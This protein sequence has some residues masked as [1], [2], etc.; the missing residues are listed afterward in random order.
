MKKKVVFQKRLL[1]EAYRKARSKGVTK[2]EWQYLN[3]VFEIYHH[4]CYFEEYLS[5]R[6]N[7]KKQAFEIEMYD[8]FKK[9]MLVIGQRIS[10]GDR[11]KVLRLLQR[12]ESFVRTKKEYSEVIKDLGRQMFLRELREVLSNLCETS[13][14]S[15]GLS[16][17]Y[18]RKMNPYFKGFFIHFLL[19][20]QGGKLSR[21]AKEVLEGGVQEAELESYLDDAERDK[22]LSDLL[23][24]GHMESASKHWSERGYTEKQ[25]TALELSGLSVLKDRAG[26]IDFHFSGEHNTLSVRAELDVLGGGVIERYI[27]MDETGNP[28]EIVNMVFVAGTCSAEGLGSQSVFSQIRAAFLEGVEEISMVA[29]EGDGDVGYKVWPKFGYN[30]YYSRDKKKLGGGIQAYFES[31]YGPTWEDEEIMISDILSAVDEEGNNIGVEWWDKNGTTFNAYFDLDPNTLSMKVFL[32]YFRRKLE[33][34]DMTAKEFFSAVLPPFDTGNADC[35]E[36]AFKRN[37]VTQEML[38]NA[39]SDFKVVY[40]MEPSRFDPY[41]D[42]PLKT[43]LSSR[44]ASRKDA[45]AEEIWGEIGRLRV[46]QAQKVEALRELDPADISNID[47]EECKI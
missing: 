37:K 30:G 20:S 2:R 35:W 1:R 21:K 17:K 42:D 15:L 27:N 45:V 31:I 23:K 26:H 39:I 11:T 47:R 44:L 40:L 10:D 3:R 14:V 36:E 22:N 38:E 41:L 13:F 29:S 33:Q 19:G 28:S 5:G 7:A 34:Y 16:L 8:T 24:E 25:I 18:R 9:S 32:K 43:W 12:L 6:W 46:T 4:I